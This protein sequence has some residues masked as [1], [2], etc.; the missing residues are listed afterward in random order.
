MRGAALA[1]IVAVLLSGCTAVRGHGSSE[2]DHRVVRQPGEPASVCE[3]IHSDLNMSNGTAS[4]AD[5]VSP[6]DTDRLQAAFDRCAQSGESVVGIRLA[7]ASPHHD[8]LSGPLTLR[9]GEV[10]ILDPDVTVY[11]SL[12]PSDY[13]VPGGAPCGTVSGDGKGCRA[14]IDVH[15]SNAGIQSTSTSDS[16]QGRID[17]RGGNQILGED[18]T[19]WEL[20]DSARKGGVQNTPRL[21]N[22]ESSNRF[23][24]ANVTLADAP[25]YHVY[26]KNGKDFTAWGVR[27]ETPGSARNTDGIDI[28]GATDV[29]IVDSWISGGDDGVGIKATSEPSAD[30]TVRG[31]HLFG[32]HG[33]SIGAVTTAGVSNV[34]VAD[35]M[36]SGLDAFGKRSDASIGI[37]VKSAPQFGGVVRGIAFRGTCIDAVTHPVVIDPD[38]L[39]KAG[40][41]P[42]TFIDIRIDGL[43]ATN[44]PA[45]ASSQLKGPRNGRPLTLAITHT[46]VDAPAIQ[47]RNAVISAENATFGGEE[48]ASTQAPSW[49]QPEQSPASP[50]SFPP[51]PKR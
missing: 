39:G 3:T 36:I 13:Q 21:I 28:D 16:T 4:L 29:S 5:E 26:Y 22:L 2:G 11:A 6:P 24:L 48:L 41:H 19:W 7:A 8:F 1:T 18:H 15:D 31:N 9:R 32:T 14:F 44:S 45:D 38:Y 47:T 42:P 33:I 50:C 10:L 30:I 37:R 46:S 23:V 51:F 34:L 40:D 49:P 17:G 35:N 43:T 25:G 27:I 20:A 12:N